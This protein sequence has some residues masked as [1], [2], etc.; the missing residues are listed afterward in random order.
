MGKRNNSKST[1]FDSNDIDRDEAIA[2]EAI[3]NLIANITVLTARKDP[4]IRSIRSP[5]LLIRGL[6]ELQSMVEMVDIKH[7]IVNQIKFLITNHARK[8]INT[9]S[10]ANFEGHMLHSVVSGNPGTGKTTVAMILSKIWMALG[11]V[12]K[13]ESLKSSTTSTNTTSNTSSNP[14]SNTNTTPNTVNDSYIRRVSELE[15]SRRNDHRKLD[16]L[17]ELLT[18]YHTVSG[19]IRRKAIQL[20]SHTNQQGDFIPRENQISDQIIRSNDYLVD[21]VMCDE[22]EWDQLLAY[23]RDLRTGFDQL[24]REINTNDIVGASTIGSSGNNQSV[25]P[26]SDTSS[27]IPDPYENEDPKFIVAAREDLIAEYLGQTAPKTKKVLES[28]LG[29]VL[30]IDEAYSICNMDGGSKDKYG[31]EC[32][33]TI[34]EFMSLHSDEI[35]IIFAGYKDELMSSIFRAQKGLLRRINYFFEIKDYTNKGLTKIFSR[36][37]AK[38]SWTLSNDVN[39][40]KYLTDNKDI[41][42]GGGG[43]TE[44]LAFQV[45][46]AYSN[47]KFDQ[48]VRMENASEIHNGIITDKMV[49]TAFM[50][51]RKSINN[52]LAENKMPLG[53]YT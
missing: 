24:I 53:M 37:L 8:L 32:L 21:R 1:F 14:T 19:E 13:K 39:I 4:L 25:T 51:L 33:S 7:S 41:M 20:K 27:D 40:E 46:L 50:D 35:I 2:N 48:T 38:D 6:K 31:E 49:K 34:N 18:K 52:V 5:N 43:F 22:K 47:E 10:Y 3:S 12:N 44:K 15:E 36:Q 17:K 23:T 45:K 30:F 26:A 29:G 9:N 42:H 16:R 11:F 28:A